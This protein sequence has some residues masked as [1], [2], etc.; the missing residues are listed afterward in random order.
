MIR[1]KNNQLSDFQPDLSLK[2]GMIAKMNKI[3]S[4]IVNEKKELLLLKESPNDPQFKK[5]IWYIV[6][7]SCE[8]VDK[9]KKRYCKKGNKRRNKFRFTKNNISK[10]DI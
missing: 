6:T 5:S 3:L 8:K 7:G 4:F 2:K 9:T 1:L 10:L